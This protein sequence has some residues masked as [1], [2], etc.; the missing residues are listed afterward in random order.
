MT[1]LRIG[2]Q[3]EVLRTRISNRVHV[4]MQKWQRDKI[5][6]E[7]HQHRAGKEI[8]SQLCFLTQH[9]RTEATSMH[10]AFPR[11][12]L[13][14]V[15]HTPSP[16]LMP[17]LSSRQALFCFTS[18]LLITHYESMLLTAHTSS[19]KMEILYSPSLPM[20]AEKVQLQHGGP[21]VSALTP[22]GCHTFIPATPHTVTEPYSNG[23]VIATKRQWRAEWILSPH[24]WCFKFSISSLFPCDK[25]HH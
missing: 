17:V 12:S 3:W 4:D 14:E 5:H 7:N 9:P 16:Q 22:K 24:K 1:L 2:I 21:L 15:Q 19:F 10:Q 18:P 23:V 20:G 11:W 6:S 8:K 13:S 25:L